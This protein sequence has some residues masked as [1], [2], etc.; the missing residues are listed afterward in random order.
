MEEIADGTFDSV[1][2]LPTPAQV[3]LPLYSVRIEAYFA[4]VVFSL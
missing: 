1:K 4:Y 3:D 2:K